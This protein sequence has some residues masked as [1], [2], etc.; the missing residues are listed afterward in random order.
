M[1]KDCSKDNHECCGEDC[2]C[3]SEDETLTM[4]L[5]L[6]DG[7]ELK[8]NVVGTFLV[9]D[10]MY[11]GLLPVGEEEVFIYRYEEIDDENIELIN[12]EDDEEFEQVTEAFFELYIDENEE[13]EQEI[14]ELLDINIDEE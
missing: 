8:C 6:D 7:T 2:S 1:S 10:L 5:V 4:D 12:I 9:E 11:I 13:Y 14:D 3:S